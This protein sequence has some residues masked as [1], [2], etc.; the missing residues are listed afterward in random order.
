[1]FIAKELL[2]LRLNFVFYYN[3]LLLKIKIASKKLQS[4]LG[5]KTAFLK[6]RENVWSYMRSVSSRPACLFTCVLKG[7]KL[8]DKDSTYLQSQSYTRECDSFIS[9]D[10]GLC[11]SACNDS[12]SWPYPHVHMLHLEKCGADFDEVWCCNLDLSFVDSEV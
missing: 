4:P 8:S 7:I 5:Y 1:L 2:L 12:L 3:F 11:K 6:C 9:F 10:L